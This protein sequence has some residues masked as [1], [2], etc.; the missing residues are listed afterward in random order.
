MVED[1]RSGVI[2]SVAE[3]DTCSE[4]A[5]L[6]AYVPDGRQDACFLISRH[7]TKLILEPS[8]RGAGVLPLGMARG[9]AGDVVSLYDPCTGLWV[10]AA[11]PV[12]ATGRMVIL[13]RRIQ[14]FEQ[15][16]LTVV[17][18]IFVPKNVEEIADR[19]DQILGSTFDAALL[20]Q[21]GAGEGPLLEACFCLMPPDVQRSFADALANTPAAARKLADL[22]PDDV[23]SKSGIVD[24]ACWLAARA[25]AKVTAAV[26]PGPRSP[27]RWW[28]R[29]QS[30]AAASA[31]EPAPTR[32][33]MTIDQSFDCMATRGFDGAYVSLPH[34]VTALARQSVQPTKDLC[35]VATARN[36]GIYFLEWLAYHRAIGV[37]QVFIYP[38]D[39]D[40]E[41]D[42]LLSRLAEAGAL[43]W[44]NSV[45]GTGGG[46]QPK[47]YGHAF[48]LNP[49]VL[50]YRW[51]LVIDLDEYLSFNPAMFRSAS[52]LLNW[53][54]T[55]APDAV[56]LNW[57]IHGS[58][59]QARWSNVTIFDRFPFALGGAGAH[60]KTLCRPNAFI[61]STP[62]FPRR[63]RNRPFTFIA[64]DGRQHLPLGDTGGLAHSANPNADFAWITHYFFRSAEEFLWKWSRNRG[65]H[66]TIA[67]PTNSVLTANFVES[68]M[69]QFHRM[70]HR[71]IGLLECAPGYTAELN[72]LMSLPGVADAHARTVQCFRDQMKTIAPLFLNADGIRKAGQ[73]GQAFMSVLGLDS[74]VSVNDGT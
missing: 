19:L 42:E 29:R 4:R 35:V 74:A 1:Q 57:V 44:I 58:A 24:L 5:A 71:G 2:I 9:T 17:N 13:Q 14:A 62:H 67:G 48:G 37:E 15:F 59:G 69:Q 11:P 8:L 34:A 60:I 39:N 43:R 70:E 18:T 30:V 53:Y 68:F 38:N 72:R 21:I 36:E 25:P 64:A 22:F 46:A 20:T 32:K 16:T 27:T 12:E 10:C 55:M 66:A 65:D 33:S 54:E 7:G 47:A 6:L 73:A 31:P 26:A 50:D 3:A 51:A 63:Y 49:E 61:H 56:A 40:D 28:T 45:V 23:T 41:S 52:D